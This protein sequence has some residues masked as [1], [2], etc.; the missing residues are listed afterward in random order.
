M[1]RGGNGKALA[2]INMVIYKDVARN[3]YCF[4]CRL[5]FLRLIEETL[6]ETDS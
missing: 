3:K 2:F 6:T 5:K 4:F 1:I